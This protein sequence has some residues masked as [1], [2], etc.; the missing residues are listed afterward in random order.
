MC[1]ICGFI[2]NKASNKENAYRQIQ[3]MNDE[4]THRGPNDRGEKVFAVNRANTVVGFGQRRLSIMDLSASGHQPMYSKSG[5]IA[6][7]FNGEIYNYRDLKISLKNDYDFTT[8]CD[9]EVIIAAYEKWGVDMFPHLDGMFAFAIYD[10]RKKSVV[11][12]RDRLGKKPLYYYTKDET[13]IISSDFVF[14]SELKCFF[15]YK[16]FEKEI[17]TDVLPRYLAKRYVYGKQTILKNVYRLEPGTYLNINLSTG[18]IKSSEYW[19]LACSYNKRH[20]TFKGTYDEAVRE[21]KALVESSVQKRMI[22]DVP[23]GAFLSGGIDS[24]LVAAVM[25]SKSVQPIHTYTIGFREPG[26]NEAE[27]AREIANYLG[28]KHTERYIEQKEMIDLVRKLAFYCDEPLGDSAIIPNMLLSEMAKEN[29]TVILTGDGG[30]EFF[31]GYDWY[32][33]SN[34]FELMGSFSFLAPPLSITYNKQD[35]LSRALFTVRANSGRDTRLQ[36]I[37]ANQAWMINGMLK[38]INILRDGFIPNIR[39]STESVFS[40]KDPV[41]KNMLFDAKTTLTDCFL[42]KTDRSTMAYS[43]EARCPLLDTSIIEYSF[44]LPTKFLYYKGNKKRLLKSLLECYVPRNLWDRPKRGFSVPVREW[45]LGEL[46]D[47]LDRVSEKAFL[48]S[49]NIFRYENVNHLIRILENKEPGYNTADFILWS[50]LMFQL[51]YE[52][53][54]M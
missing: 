15:K 45:M 39:Y 12:G 17:C 53:W 3:L 40:T 14:A 16:D 33:K 9:T 25:Q 18:C 42:V 48:E 47:D 35:K 37:S 20:D 24:S 34:L 36:P 44:T 13:S 50:Y 29:S 8:D 46:K 6:I 22:A 26:Y 21:L 32:E 52:K 19:S 51:W 10:I 38:S 5:D 41:R 23:I 43:L 31:C 27:Y 30:D 4:M 2:S 28:C 1:G 11:I 7:I 54:M 49:Q